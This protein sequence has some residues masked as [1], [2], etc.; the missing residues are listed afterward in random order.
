MGNASSFFGD[1]F[2]E[3]EDD[4]LLG[5][6]PSESPSEREG[7]PAPDQRPSWV[8]ESSRDGK[9]SRSD[10]P[11]TETAGGAGDQ[12]APSEKTVSVTLGGGE[13][14]NRINESIRGGWRL[15]HVALDRRGDAS[16]GEGPPTKVVMTLRR[17]GA[18]SLF[19][20][21]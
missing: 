7:S 14:L 21:S 16:R 5:G 13:A 18:S 10:A 11:R 3:P 6:G 17:E 1:I 12:D 20:F 8:E 19:D 2:D 15:F 4:P 9:P